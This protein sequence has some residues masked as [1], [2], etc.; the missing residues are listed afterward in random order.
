MEPLGPVPSSCVPGIGAGGAH[1]SRCEVL[2]GHPFHKKGDDELRAQIRRAAEGAQGI[3]GVDAEAEAVYISQ[4]NDAMTILG[5]RRHY[6]RQALRH[7]ELGRLR[8]PNGCIRNS[9]I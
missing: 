8:R 5:A 4:L 7:E 1:G 9:G 6:Q 2:L 3:R